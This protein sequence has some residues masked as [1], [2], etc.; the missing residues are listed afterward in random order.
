MDWQRRVK[1]EEEQ[2]IAVGEMWVLGETMTGGR[3]KVIEM[4]AGDCAQIFS[5]RTV[6]VHVLT[7]FKLRN[8]TMLIV[9]S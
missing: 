1:R 9:K 8:V 3:L 7:S 2:E 5:S 4:Q 6:W